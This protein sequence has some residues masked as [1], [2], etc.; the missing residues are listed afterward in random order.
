MKTI[1]MLIFKGFMFLAGRLPGFH[2]MIRHFLRLKMVAGVQRTQFLF[3]RNF[4]FSKGKLHVEDRAG[5][6]PDSRVLVGTKSSY[7][8]IPSSKYFDVQ[9][10]EKSWIPSSEKRVL[11]NEEWVCIREFELK[12][13]SVLPHLQRH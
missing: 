13:L 8:F 10:L 11:K 4:H 7:A 9:E 2:A 1:T 3:K 6:P 12:K 5:V